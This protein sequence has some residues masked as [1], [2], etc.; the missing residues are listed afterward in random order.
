M[1][2][3]EIE[4]NSSEIGRVTG[5]WH[6]ETENCYARSDMTVIDPGG[7]TPDSGKDGLDLADGEYNTMQFWASSVNFDF[8]IVWDWNSV[9]GLPILR[10]AGGF[11]NHT[12]K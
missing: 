11:Q 12:V 5:R 3:I 4:E 6:K 9:T 8:T 10:N 2:C 1:E 7:Y